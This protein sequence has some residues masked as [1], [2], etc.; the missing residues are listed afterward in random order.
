MIEM[1]LKNHYKLKI[2]FFISN[3]IILVFVVMLSNY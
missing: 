3:F 2:T 1:D